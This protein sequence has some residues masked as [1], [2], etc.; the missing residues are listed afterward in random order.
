MAVVVIAI[1][2]THAVPTNAADTRTLR[3]GEATLTVP[4]TCET[5][6]S[7]ENVVRC[8]AP[9][10]DGSSFFASLDRGL[11][12]PWTAEAAMRELGVTTPPGDSAE[13]QLD[14]AFRHFAKGTVTGVEHRVSAGDL[15][16]NRLPGDADACKVY[17]IEQFGKDPAIGDMTVFERGIFC[18]SQEPDLL[19][20][21]HVAA[22]A[23]AY[24]PG[25]G[26][27]LPEGTSGRLDRVLATFRLR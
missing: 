24:H 26:Q 17:T 4:G 5:V 12:D 16:R 10:A 6:R 1:F 7:S 11:F 21:T 2:V 20:R 14:I 8:R 22:A 13:R 27:T 3:L 15:P 19:H 18:I 25:R 23:H 9:N